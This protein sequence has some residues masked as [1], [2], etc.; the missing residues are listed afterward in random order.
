ML[1]IFQSIR[2]LK[3]NIFTIML[4]ATRFRIFLPAWQNNLRQKF[5]SI[6]T[7]DCLSKIKSTE[8]LKG[9]IKRKS[10]FSPGP[11]AK[12]G[13]R[14]YFLFSSG[15]LW[16]CVKTAKFFLN[17]TKTEGNMCLRL[18]WRLKDFPDMNNN[19]SSENDICY[20]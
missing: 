3:F 7:T 11:G 15:F 9:A 12:K 4:Y 2:L 6:K 19:I 16:K 10:S 18:I 1:C 17:Q 13:V 8:K 20:F 5:I 14:K